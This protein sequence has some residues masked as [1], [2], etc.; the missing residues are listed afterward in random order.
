[1]TA[2]TWH[3]PPPKSLAHCVCQIIRKHMRPTW[4]RALWILLGFFLAFNL[5]RASGMANR[6]AVPAPPIEP[7]VLTP[8]PD[9]AGPLTPES[10]WFAGGYKIPR[11]IHQT[12]RSERIP[13][14]LRAFRDSWSRFNKGWEVRVICRMS[15]QALHTAQGTLFGC[16][17][18]P[19]LF[20]SLFYL[21]HSYA[22]ALSHLVCRLLTPATPFPAW[23]RTMTTPLTQ[24][25]ACVLPSY[26][27]PLL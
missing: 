19:F 14:H 11:V 17:A 18:W 15:R 12:Y 16:T 10:E 8:D 4:V 3:P 9:A 26:A 2:R 25:T 20:L 21:P 7:S 24:A 6:A 13:S 5:L 22:T 27:G 1:M 23:G